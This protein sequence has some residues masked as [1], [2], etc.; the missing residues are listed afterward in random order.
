MT[1]LEASKYFG[2]VDLVQS[3]QELRNDVKLKRFSLAVSLTNPLLLRQEESAKKGIALDGS[4]QK[5]SR[6]SKGKKRP[7]RR[8]S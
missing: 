1:A 5:L 4:S 3:K 2:G 7:H 6:R 8:T